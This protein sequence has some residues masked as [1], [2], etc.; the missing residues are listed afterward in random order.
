MTE[1]CSAIGNWLHRKSE[2]PCLRLMEGGTVK[3]VEEV[4]EGVHI[5]RS[6]SVLPLM[7]GQA[8]LR[9]LVRYGAEAERAGFDFKVTSDHHFP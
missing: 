7:A 5:R 9:E 8:A 3:L 2:V 1:G 4:M 6:P